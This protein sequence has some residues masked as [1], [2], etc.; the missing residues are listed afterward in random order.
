M[1]TVLSLHQ[2][3]DILSYGFYLLVFFVTINQVDQRA[4]Y[5]G[6]IGVTRD[7]GDMLGRREA[8]TNREGQVLILREAT[9]ACD[10][11]LEMRRKLI[12]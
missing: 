7:P 4:A 10:E 9:H 5:N 8:E 1:Y 6:S 2:T 11:V 3:L 12:S